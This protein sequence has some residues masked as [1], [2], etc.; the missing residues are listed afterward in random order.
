MTQENI[1]TKNEINELCISIDEHSSISTSQKT[2]V[3]IVIGLYTNP[4]VQSDKNILS[5]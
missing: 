4:F 5:L 1:L 3:K 2:F